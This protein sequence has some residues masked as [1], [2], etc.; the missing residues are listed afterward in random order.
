MFSLVV[1]ISLFMQP[2]PADTSDPG[3][4]TRFEISDEYTWP[5]DASSY[6]SGTFGETRSVHFHAA[7][8]IK[9]WARKGYRVFAARDGKIFRVA[10]GPT[11]YGKVI[12]LKH[13]DGSY[14]V[15]AHLLSFRED[16]QHYV[17][18][19]RLRDYSFELDR[20]VDSLNITVSRGDVIGYSGA[21]GVGPPHLH[22]EL[23]TP[24]NKPFNPLLTN[25]TIPDDVPPRFSGLTIEPLTEYSRI[26]GGHKIYRRKAALNGGNY[27]FGTIDVSGPVGLG[28]DVFDQANRVPN[29]YAVY[30]LKLLLE[31]KL[32]FHSKVDSF[33]Y[34]ETDQLFLDR[35]YPI[36][37]RTGRGYQR[38]FLKDGNTLPFY[39]QAQSNGKIDLDPGSYR[40]Q[41]VARDYYGNEQPAYLTLN[42][43]EPTFPASPE[44]GL[45][46]ALSSDPRTFSPGQLEQ[47]DWDT[48][49]IR[50]NNNSQ[51]SY[52]VISFDMDNGSLGSFFHT[53]NTLDL[54]K[55]TKLL[56]E[57][58]NGERL[59][60]KR[61]Y[62]GEIYR[63][64]SRGGRLM[65]KFPRETF[66]DTLTVAAVYDIIRDDSIRVDLYPKDQPVKNEFRIMFLKDQL[67][68][69]TTGMAFYYL[70][71]RKNKLNY[72]PTDQTNRLFTAMAENMGTYY[73]LP[74]S[75][76]PE[77]SNPN[78]YRRRDGKWMV[79][80]TLTDN[81]SG[82]NYRELEMYVNGVRGIP[83]YEPENDLVHYYHPDF[84][85]A[86]ENRIRVVAED[87]AGNRSKKE[88]ILN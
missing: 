24:S 5:T 31:D 37:K 55:H 52:S 40:L 88:F 7:L 66:Y 71:P 33:S 64:S 8:D 65:F 34:H 63:Y 67:S 15:Y 73:I 51:D 10:I 21:S 68:A 45:V 35:V 3:L 46:R 56:I 54:S 83:E 12:Y 29:A 39:K 77:L 17:D 23:R 72:L 47:W 78:L 62:P 59:H 41:I 38:L 50:F 61:I 14:S 2:Q 22:F 43:S 82:I 42:V 30:E 11:G 36:L 76:S 80:V 58:G 6:A 86:S 19:L 32:L 81:R 70:D 84:T 16:L 48:D 53:R 60:L 25:L 85:P 13:R 49:W 79:S 28:V 44:P 26:E 18:S 27:D 69:D 75:V 57:N 1:L 87:H 9:T 20:R 74:D 4:G